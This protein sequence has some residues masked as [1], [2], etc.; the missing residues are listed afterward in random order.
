MRAAIP[1]LTSMHPSFRLAISP[2]F[3]QLQ[4]HT[5][6]AL[7][8]LRPIEALHGA[9]RLNMS[10]KRSLRS[11]AHEELDSSDG[12]NAKGQAAPSLSKLTKKP[13]LTCGRV[14]TPRSNWAT[15]WAEIK[16]CS[17]AC[18][19]E[20]RSKMTISWIPADP[21]E[22]Q[23]LL[24]DSSS[25]NSTIHWLKTAQIPNSHGEP[26]R[27][28]TDEWMEAILLHIAHADSPKRKGD[29]FPT[30]EDAE[31]IIKQELDTMPAVQ[32]HSSDESVEAMH[33]VRLAV[34]S[35]PGLRE[36]VRRAL[37]R[38]AVLPASNLAPS[39]DRGTGSTERRLYLRQ[40]KRHLVTLE[41]VSF[42]KGPIELSLQEP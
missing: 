27:L 1:F 42:A 20:K 39:G 26:I 40:R 35:H 22:V 38:L 5:A 29:P 34:T 14:I 33:P 17:D 11:K 2:L 16:Y 15:N 21:E 13:C 23:R 9:N 3:L 30:G 4:R 32:Q 10:G 41:D 7:L 8:P 6:L 12:A 31:S 37:R 19:K 28:N 24:Q 18:R 25:R 36:R